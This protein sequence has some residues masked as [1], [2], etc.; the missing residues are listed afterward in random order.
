MKKALFTTGDAAAIL[1]PWVSR[2]TV[3]RYFDKG[4]LGGV[5]NPITGKRMI[6]FDSL[7]TF[8]EKHGVDIKSNLRQIAGIK[9]E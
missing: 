7:M 9:N 6:D 8:A 4:I 1:H 3:S 5:K 2:S